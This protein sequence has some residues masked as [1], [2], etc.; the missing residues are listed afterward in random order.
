MQVP[1][2][3]CTT[4]YRQATLVWKWYSS[5]A[6]HWPCSEPRLLPSTFLLIRF[7]SALQNIERLGLE[8]SQRGCVLGSGLPT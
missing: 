5:Q 7:V 3:L 4:V 1:L 2:W 6:P 8:L